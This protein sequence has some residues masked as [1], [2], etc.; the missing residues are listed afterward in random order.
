MKFFT[1]RAVANGSSKNKKAKKK[2][3]HRKQNVKESFG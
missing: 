3:C 2:V 1:N